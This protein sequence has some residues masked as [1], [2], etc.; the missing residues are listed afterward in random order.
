ML[1][2]RKIPTVLDLSDPKY[3]DLEYLELLQVCFEKEIEL[4]EE[5]RLQIEEDTRSQSQGANFFKHRAG[6]I[7]ASQSK[8][9]SHTNPGC[10]AATFLTSELH[11]T[12]NTGI[13]FCPSSANFGEL[14]FCLK[15]LVNGTLGSTS[16]PKCKVINSQKQAA[17]AITERKLMRKVFFVVIL[18][19][20]LFIFIYHVSRLTAFQKHGI[21]PIAET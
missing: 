3:Q 17:F 8:Q 18:N 9:A 13:Q 14:V 4:F 16:H 7:G 10:G 19:V 12:K 5:Q 1:K 11:L 21:A 20:P 6:R 15:C 2:S